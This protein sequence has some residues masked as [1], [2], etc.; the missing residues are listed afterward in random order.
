MPLRFLVRSDLHVRKYIL[1]TL[2]LRRF[3]PE[4]I[5]TVLRSKF[6]AP[7][8]GLVLLDR[9]DQICEQKLPGSYV[10][11]HALGG[12]FRSKRELLM[13]DMFHEIF[14]KH[15]GDTTAVGNVLEFLEERSHAAPEL[16]Y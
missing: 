4:M 8:A 10:A 7:A 16:A 1:R 3:G 6:G 15:R 11:R 12:C 2:A 5:D 14:M 9:F 13:F